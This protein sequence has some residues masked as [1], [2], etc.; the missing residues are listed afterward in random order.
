MAEPPLPRA[1]RIIVADDH[2][3]IRQALVRMVIETLPTAEIIEAAD[4]LEALQAYQQ[5]GAD[6]LVTDHQMPRMDG[7]TLVRRVRETAPNLPTL[8]VSVNADARTDALAAGATWFL[9]KEEIGARLPELLRGHASS[10]SAE[11]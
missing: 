7:M 1:P 2:Q 9:S 11:S 4:G 10:S 6:F 5:G 3:W 8:M